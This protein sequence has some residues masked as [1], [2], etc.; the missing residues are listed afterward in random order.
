MFRFFIIVSFVPILSVFSINI[1][2]GKLFFY[3]ILSI[4]SYFI[5]LLSINLIFYFLSKKDL[6]IIN[7]IFK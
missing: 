2:E 6:R 1:Y 7:Y 4:D 5:I 3:K